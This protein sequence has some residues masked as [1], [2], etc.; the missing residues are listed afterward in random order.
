MLALSLLTMQWNEWW[1][2]NLLANFHLHLAVVGAALMAFGL[3]WRRWLQAGIGA[4][5]IL[6]NIGLVASQLPPAAAAAVPGPATLRVMTVNVLFDNR[7]A[8]ALRDHIVAQ[9]PDVV[10]M[11]EVNRRW[12]RDLTVLNDLYP[13]RLTL[14]EAKPLLDDHGTVLFSRY[15][16]TEYARPALGGI[17]GRLTAARLSVDGHPVWL[18]ST[19]LVKPS[20]PGGQAL[21]RLQ[22]NA[23][24]RWAASV[25]GPLVIGGDFNATVYMPQLDGLLQSQGFSTD[26]QSGQWWKVAVGTYP[27]WLPLLGLKIDHILAR[28]AAIAS[29]DIVTIKGSDHRAVVANLVLPAQH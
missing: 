19:H 26:L 13:H 9:E 22:L 21:Q 15:P 23:L 27:S 29:S 1:A 3:V 25:S 18:A 7:N 14:M 6:A 5:I 10:L 11:Q 8:A 28:D 4:A 24:G 12:N 2:M 17:E 20:T 16:I